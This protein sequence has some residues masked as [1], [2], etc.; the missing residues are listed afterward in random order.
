MGAWPLSQQHS[1]PCLQGLVPSPG[2][3]QGIGG[4]P[5]SAQLVVKGDVLWKCGVVSG[6]SDPMEVSAGAQCDLSGL[7]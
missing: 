1:G 2:A 3:A 7:L 5:V 4:H 6:L